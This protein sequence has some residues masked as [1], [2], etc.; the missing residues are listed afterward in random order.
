MGRLGEIYECNIKEG[1]VF[2]YL[3]TLEWTLQSLTYL[4]ILLKIIFNLFK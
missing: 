4:L 3:H 1:T 2:K